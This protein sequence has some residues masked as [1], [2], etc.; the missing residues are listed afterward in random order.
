[1]PIFR[2]TI[3]YDDQLLGHFESDLPA[4]LQAIRKI[5]ASLSA[6]GY[7]LDLLVAHSERR[8]LET[9]PDGVRMISREPLFA[10]APLKQ[11]LDSAP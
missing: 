4:A 5:A 8:L 9:G 6:S 1:M 7:S 2:L 3:R 11:Y 10:P